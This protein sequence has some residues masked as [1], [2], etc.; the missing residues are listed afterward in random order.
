MKLLNKLFGNKEKDAQIDNLVRQIQQNRD[1]VDEGYKKMQKELVDLEDALTKEQDL[2]AEEAVMNLEMSSFVISSFDKT[3]KFLESLLVRKLPASVKDEIQDF[4]FVLK[5]QEFELQKLMESSEKK[6]NIA[7]RNVRSKNPVES[8][9]KETEPPKATPLP[10]EGTP[11]RFN[12]LDYTSKQPY[13]DNFKEMK[14]QLEKNK[15]AEAFHGTIKVTDEKGESK[16]VNL[17]SVKEAL[18]Y[19]AR[20]EKGEIAVE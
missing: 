16:T 10:T 14:K 2:R 17:K 19:I 5:G 18:E 1:L 9:F 11:V 7:N 4:F 12:L 13:E 3:R 15:H 20:A 6:D 8:F